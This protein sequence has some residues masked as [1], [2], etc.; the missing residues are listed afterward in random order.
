[1]FLYTPGGRDILGV[2]DSQMQSVLADS[3]ITVNEAMVNSDIDLQLSL[4]RVEPV[5]LSLL[6]DNPNVEHNVDVSQLL[7]PDNLPSTSCRA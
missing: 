7:R 2:S 4:V 1:M 6:T 3:L 5:S